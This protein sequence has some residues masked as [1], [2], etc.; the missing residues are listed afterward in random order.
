[1]KEE[2]TNLIQELEKLRKSYPKVLRDYVEVGREF[3]NKRAETMLLVFDQYAAQPLRDAAVEKNE[4]MQDIMDKWQ[5]AEYE[6][7]LWT[8]SNWILNIQ[9][10]LLMASTYPSVG[11]D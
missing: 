7:N 9:A 5:L 3:R 10:K 11:G 4:D 6:F 2:Y 8:Q 1:M